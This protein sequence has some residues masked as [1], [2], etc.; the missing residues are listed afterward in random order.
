MTIQTLFKPDGPLASHIDGFK[1]RAPQLEMAEAVARAIKSGGRLLVEAGT[2]TGKTYAYLVPALE[3]GKRVVISTGSKNLQEQLFYRDLPTITGA[4]SY[5]PPVALLKGRSNYLC[6][7]RMNR[8]LSESHL[9]KPEVLNDL[10]KVK[11]WSTATDNGDVGDI[12]GLQENAE[13]LAHVT[14]TNDNC[15]GRDCPYYDDCHLVV[16]RRRAMDAQV[17][18]INHHLFFA[19][20]AVKDTGFGELVPEAQVYVFDEAHQLAE[21]AT[22]YFG[23]SVGSRTVQD[24]AQDIQLAYRAEAHDMAQLGK[25]ADR[26]AIASQDL[27]LAFGV[28]GGRGNTRDMLRQPLWGQA[29]ARLNDA[30]G[31][32]YEV[33]KLALGRGEQLDHAFE[34]ICELRTRLGDVLAVNQ[35][36]FSYWYDC[37]RL[38]F[39]LNLTPLSVAERFSAEV[40]KPEVAWVF[41]SATLTVDMRFDHFKAE[42]GLAG[43]AELILDSPFDYGEQARLCVPRYLP[44]PNA[45][46]RG[47]QLANLMIPL[48]NKTPGGC[49][50]LC[51]SHQV[52]RQVAE[53][54]R[55][56]IG[57]TVLLQ[58]ED[59]KQRLLKEFVENGRAVLVATSSFWEGIDVRGAALSCVIIDKL[60]FASP[61]DPQLKAR[62]DD[63][64]LKGGDPFVELQ[65]PKAVIALKQGVGRL[66]RDRSDHGVLVICDPRMVN[67]PYG[68]TFIKSL[69]A[70]PRTR[71]LG[72][73]GSFFDRTEHG[74]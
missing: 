27:R 10:V 21:I 64:K 62:V 66:I 52:M 4:L 23:K 33:L 8:L 31:L 57:R 35:T 2:G 71:E 16:A 1:A 30:I 32:C 65:L 56:E 38:H 19:D 51:T 20:M 53:V 36:G 12:P 11:S 70:I 5:I 22:N 55:R 24:L 26:L 49:F 60:P 47:E 74:E 67:K 29:L 37:S 73:L 6:I 40:Q 50:F 14:S 7:E 63:C 18:V 34:R 68:A 15:L 42:L 54:L 43:S 13:I 39:S 25:A 45:F 17:V 44:E 46:G 59:N 41:T 72:T 69:P 58:G 9:Q 28:D 48:I 61:D 3:S